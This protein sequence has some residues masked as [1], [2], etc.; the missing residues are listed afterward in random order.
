MQNMDLT[1]KLAAG[2][3]D[4]AQE[5]SVKFPHRTA[6][7]AIFIAAFYAICFTGYVPQ[8]SFTLFCPAALGAVYW[9]LA[10]EGLLYEKKAAFFFLPV[11]FLA[12][13]NGIFSENPFTYTNILVMH[14]L[15]VAFLL[16][17]T[18]PYRVD[19]WSLGFIRAAKR[20][21]IGKSIFSFAGAVKAFARQR[22][23][24]NSAAQSGDFI[25]VLQ[26]VACAAPFL[27]LIGGLL[28]EGDQVFRLFTSD[29]ADMLAKMDVAKRVFI[30]GLVFVYT[31]TCL[32]NLLQMQ[33]S[34]AADH[35]V[36]GAM[37]SV[38]S[39]SFL[40]V[41]NLLFL[42]FS[43]IQFAF[44]FNGGWLALP[45]GVN[46][47]TYA[48][49]GF[50]ELLFV[51]VVNFAI[52]LFFSSS[53]RAGAERAVKGLLALLCAFTGVLI[54][55]SAYRMA[56]YIGTYGYTPLR[57]Q[58]VTFLAMESILIAGS[59][60]Y[61]LHKR[62]DLARFYL[63]IGL[64]FYILVNFTSSDYAVTALNI[65]RF[66]HDENA[67]IDL[68]IV[69]KDGAGLILD[70]YKMEKFQSGLYV[71]SGDMILHSGQTGKAR[72]PDKGYWRDTVTAPASWQEWTLLGRMAEEKIAAIL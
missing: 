71:Q 50:F 39:V 13:C 20:V 67:A 15:F 22:K 59:I 47:A 16:A 23:D 57:V 24:I 9:F 6:P 25:K 42:S 64:V 11:T 31:V 5:T 43:V 49:E 36:V 19:F 41:I 40:S 37:D 53:I 30:A 68:C 69:E 60:V 12:L 62:F 45:G 26:G 56:L 63:A 28:S 3:L 18:S 51:T 35:S 2:L 48:R 61:I 44:L 38:R 4:R 55:S 7:L 46:Y 54:V 27:L 32:Y 58:V 8:L 33:H 65:D 14:I 1:G 21:A 34:P 72:L 29:F 10:K 70:L 52:I 66:I 17:A